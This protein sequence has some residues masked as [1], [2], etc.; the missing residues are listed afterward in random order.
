MPI[1]TAEKSTLFRHHRIGATE[2][3]EQFISSQRQGGTAADR[4]Q[5]PKISRIA[6]E[7]KIASFSV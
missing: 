6:V 3:V 1:D 7:W 2:G 5:I 4:P